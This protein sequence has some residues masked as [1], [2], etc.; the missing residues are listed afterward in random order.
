MKPPTLDKSVLLQTIGVLAAAVLALMWL[1]AYPSPAAILLLGLLALSYLNYLLGGRDVLYPAFTFTAIWTAATLVYLLCPIDIRPLGWKTIGIFLAGTTSFSIGSL[2]GNRPFFRRYHESRKTEE[3]HLRDNRQARL[4]LLGYTVLTVPIVVY[5]IQQVVGQRI[6]ISP[7]FF[8]ALRSKINYLYMTN[9]DVSPYGGWLMNRL[10]TTGFLIAVLTFFVFVM[11]EKR[12]WAKII[13]FSCLVILSLLFTGR[14]LF[15]QAACGWIC[16]LLMQRKNRSFL[17]IAKWS[18]A[19]GLGLVALMTGLTL[20]TK[21]ETQ[22]AGGVQVATNM[23]FEYIAGPMAGFDYAVY[24]PGEFRE[25]P[26]TVFEGVLVPLAKLGLIRYTPPKAVDDFVSVP[27]P[28][29]VY[30]CFKPYYDDFGIAGCLAA[31]TLIGFVEGCVYFAAIGETP[32]AA[33]LLACLSFALMFSVFDDAYHLLMTNL[34]VVTFA[35]AYFYLL[36]GFRIRL[37][38]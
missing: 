25:Q 30:T 20:L 22:G 10:V 35:F 34:Y 13:S 6:S 29:N 4:M 14:T 8:I 37:W 31:F 27:F 32:F 26:A 3:L 24:H 12:K 1:A 36:K 16:L 33:F 7:V 15:M 11:E 19:V 2:I 38:R 21:S 23:T 18:A 9:P 28:T 17:A 5:D